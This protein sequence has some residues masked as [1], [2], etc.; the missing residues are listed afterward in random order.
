M[1]FV[2]FTLF[3]SVF[4]GLI[5]LSFFKEYTQREQMLRH[6]RELKELELRSQLQYDKGYEE[7]YH[8]GYGD[9]YDRGKS[10]HS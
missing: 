2:Y 1:I 10:D 3:M 7:G 8:I 5:G 4:V 6:E 9:G